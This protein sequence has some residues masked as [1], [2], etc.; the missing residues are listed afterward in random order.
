M[1]WAEAVANRQVRVQEP[2]IEGA[3]DGGDYDACPGNTVDP[4]QLAQDFWLGTDIDPP[5]PTADPGRALV[6]LKTYLEVGGPGGID[7]SDPTGVISISGSPT[8][9]I[10]WGDGGPTYTTADRGLPYP[11]GP[12]EITHVYSNAA[13]VTI[14]VTA[15]WTGTW[16]VTLPGVGTSTGI[17]PA[18]TRVS[19]VSL[20]VDQVQAVREH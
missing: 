12:G 17:L 11:G 6:G 19:S 16:S 8:Y 4:A 20:P 18:I 5:A 1:T 7:L 15:T 9:T 13:T 3:L 14:T 2:A 10:D